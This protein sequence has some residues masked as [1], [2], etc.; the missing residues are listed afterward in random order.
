MSSIQTA[1]SAMGYQ[2]A[3]ERPSCS[4]CHHSARR[5][6]RSRSSASAGIQC[7]KGGFLVSA[8][9]TCQQHQPWQP[10]TNTKEHA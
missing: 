2:A 1:M 3:S 8:Y 4:N 7:K 5:G 6:D 9:S 10:T